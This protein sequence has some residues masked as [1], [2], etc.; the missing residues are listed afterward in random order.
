MKRK[1][2]TETADVVEQENPWKQRIARMKQYQKDN[3]TTWKRNEKLLF[4]ATEDDKTENEYAYGW[5][6]V[7]SLETAI[8]VSNPDV[9]VESRDSS[10][11]ELGNLLTQIVQF[12]VEQMDVKSADVTA[13]LEVLKADKDSIVRGEVDYALGKLKSAR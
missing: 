7:K 12:D 8:Y 10:K 3:S 4:G 9:I 11:R 1:K 6:L 13:T 2:K 5:G